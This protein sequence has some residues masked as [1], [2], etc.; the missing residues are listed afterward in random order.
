[1][2]V[3]SFSTDQLGTGRRTIAI[4][5]N[6]EKTMILKILCKYLKNEQHV[7]TNQ[8]TVLSI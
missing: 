4:K 3:R 8:T 7:L 1:M 2:K 6:P 5:K